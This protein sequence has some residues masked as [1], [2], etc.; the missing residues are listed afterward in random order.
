M[1]LTPPPK[2]TLKQDAEFDKKTSRQ[3]AAI[4][5]IISFFAPFVGPFLVLIISDDRFVKDHAKQALN[6]DIMIFLYSIIPFI[7]FLIGFVFTAGESFGIA[8][9]LGIVGAVLL[10]IFTI[11]YFVYP[12]IG[13]VK[14]ISGKKY[15]FPFIIRLLR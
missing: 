1:T 11:M 13:A 10:L 5:Q 9:I 2:N 4:T 15:R 6:F 3:I 8:L 12:I 14:A 7:F